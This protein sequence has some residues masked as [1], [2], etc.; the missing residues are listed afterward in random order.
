MNLTTPHHSPPHTGDS[1]LR[2]ACGQ[3]NAGGDQVSGAAAGHGVD[4]VPGETVCQDGGVLPRV[5]P[6][7]WLLG[8]QGT[9]ILSGFLFGLMSL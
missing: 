2:V 5:P 6:R 3:D 7:D 4:G 1:G 8:L 9:G